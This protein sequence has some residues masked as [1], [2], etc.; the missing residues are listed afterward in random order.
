MYLRL[1]FLVKRSK[2]TLPLYEKGKAMTF[3][4]IIID[5]KAELNFGHEA[6]MP[7][8]VGPFRCFGIAALSDVKPTQ[9]VIG[10]F[11]NPIAN[12]G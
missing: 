8:E 10:S 2:D 9:N 7:I 3:F 6:E 1:Q 5:G 4:M 11:M 12:K